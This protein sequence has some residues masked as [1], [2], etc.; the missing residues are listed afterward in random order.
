MT[1]GSPETEQVEE[2]W[3]D[4]I[5]PSSMSPGRVSLDRLPNPG[6]ARDVRLTTSSYQDPLGAGPEVASKVRVLGDVVG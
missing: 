3:G 2:D 6:K 5:R 1:K 4:G